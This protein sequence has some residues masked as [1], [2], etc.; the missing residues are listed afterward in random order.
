MHMDNTGTFIVYLFAYDYTYMLMCV[1]IY[2]CARV[3]GLRH[4]VKRELREEK[5]LRVDFR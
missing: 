5:S 2:A 1:R 3:W 4:T